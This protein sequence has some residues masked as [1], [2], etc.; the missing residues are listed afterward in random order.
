MN[1]ALG[2]F[3]TQNRLAGIILG[4]RRQHPIHLTRGDQLARS[5]TGGE[6]KERRPGPPPAQGRFAGMVVRKGGDFVV[7]ALGAD[8]IAGVA[9]SAEQRGG[10]LGAGLAQF[11]IV[12]FPGQFGQGCV[13]RARSGEIA[14]VHVLA[15]Q[16]QRGLGL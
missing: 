1:R 12:V 7:Q 3:V 16:F 5:A 11:G 10:A 2:Q 9:D 8:D 6:Q 15:K 13:F 4:Q 14:G